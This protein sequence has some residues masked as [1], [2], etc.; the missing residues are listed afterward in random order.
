MHRGA[1]N[2]LSKNKTDDESGPSTVTPFAAL[3][4]S[5]ERSEVPVA[6]GSEMLRFAQHD[7]M[8]TPAASPWVSP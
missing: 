4:A 1:D 7:S 8:F 3:R 5:S 2:G 6:M